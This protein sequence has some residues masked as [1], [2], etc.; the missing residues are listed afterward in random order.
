MK[1][2]SFLALLLV[3]LFLIE[4]IPLNKNNYTYADVAVNYTGQTNT[5]TYNI[6]TTEQLNLLATKVNSG[7]GYSGS[8]FILQNN[9]IYD[10][11]KNK[12]NY[13][14]IGNAANPFSGTF[15]GNGYTISG[16]VSN[17]FLEYDKAKAEGKISDVGIFGRIS[18]AVIKNL[19][20]SNVHFVGYTRVGGI[21]GTAN[22][23]QILDCEALSDVKVVLYNI[24]GAY[25]DKEC[26][27]NIIGYS[28]G[29]T[30]KNC[31]NSSKIAGGTAGIIGYNAGTVQNCFNSG[32]A[33]FTTKTYDVWRNENASNPFFEVQ[34]RKNYGG[35]AFY[36]SSL[37]EDCY[38]LGD[39]LNVRMV[40]GIVFDML[41]GNVTRCYNKGNLKALEFAHGI[42]NKAYSGNS[43]DISNCYNSGNIEANIVSGIMGNVTNTSV[44]YCYNIGTLKGKLVAGI[45]GCNGSLDGINITKC[46]NVGTLT[47][48]G[49]YINDYEEDRNGNIRPV[50]GWKTAG[51]LLEDSGRD[52]GIKSTCFYLNSITSS[53]PRVDGIAKTTMQMKADDFLPLINPIDNNIFIPDLNNM[54]SGYPIFKWQLQIQDIKVTGNTTVERGGITTLVVEANHDSPEKQIIPSVRSMSM[55]SDTLQV[56]STSNT[57]YTGQT[58]IGTY[59]ISTPEQLNLLSTKVNSGITYENSTFIVL[60]DIDFGKQE[61]YKNQTLIKNFTSIGTMNNPFMGMFDGNDKKISNIVIEVDRVGSG[62]G[63]GDI[64]ADLTNE[65]VYKGLFGHSRGTIKNVNIT[66]FRQVNH[67][68]NARW[69]GILVGVNSGIV[70]NCVVVEDDEHLFLENNWGTIKKIHRDK[71]PKSMVWINNGD[72]INCQNKYSLSVYSSW[73]NT[74][75][76]IIAGCGGIATFNHGTIK[77][78]SNIAE[79]NYCNADRLARG[80]GAIA[81]TNLG[82]IEDCFN[83]SNIRSMDIAG[84]VDTNQGTVQRCYNTGGVY[85]NSRDDMEAA[86]I[87]RYN[88]TTG[89]ITDCYNTG[90][91]SGVMETGGIVGTNMG[92]VKGSYNTGN[93]GGGGYSFIYNPHRYGFGGIAGILKGGRIEY[94]YNTG[95]IS[96]LFGQS[97]GIVGAREG[98]SGKIISSYNVG[99][100]HQ[101]SKISGGIIGWN[102]MLTALN[103]NEYTTEE[104]ERPN[105]TIRPGQTVYTG[106]REYN[107]VINS[108]F[109]KDKNKCQ[110]LSMYVGMLTNI[111]DVPQV[112]SHSD[113]LGKSTAQ[114]QEQ[115]FIDMLN[116]SGEKHFIRDIYFTN[117]GYPIFKWQQEKITYD[118]RI[119]NSEI[120]SITP[121]LD[122]NGV[123]LKGLKKGKTILRVSATYNGKII[124]KKVTIT[125]VNPA[126]QT[127][128]GYYIIGEEIE[129][130]TGYSDDDNDP[131]YRDEFKYIHTPNRLEVGINLDNTTGTINYNNKW[132]GDSVNTF[133]KVGA[134]EVNYRVQ[135]NPPTASKIGFENY[136]YYSESVKSTIYI[137]RKP[138]AYFTILN[139]SVTDDSY[140]LDHSISY[141]N[142]GIIKW[143]W[144]YINDN[145]KILTYTATDKG[146]GVNTVNGW[147]S[148]NLGVNYE[149]ILRVQDMEFVWSEIYSNRIKG[150]IEFSANLRTELEKFDLINGVPAS[151][152]L[153]AFDIWTRYA[154]ELRLE[155][156]LCDI[157][158]KEVAP[159]LPVKY[160]SSTATRIGQDTYW[161][162]VL[163]NIPV[164]L[165]SGKY[166]MK[167]RAIDERDSNVFKE[168]PF[169][170]NVKTPINL[171]PVMSNE[172]RAGKEINIAATTSK[173][174]NSAHGGSGVKVTLFDGTSYARTLTMNGTT[175]NWDITTT[176]EKTIPQGVYKAKFVATLPSGELEEKVVNYNFV[177]NTAP[178]IT[179]GEI[180]AELGGN[181]IYENDD[182]NFRLKFHDIDLSSLDID[183]KLYNFSNLTTP[184][185]SYK[186]TVNP[187][188]SVY[189]DY[190]VRL[191]DDIP[192]GDYRVV[193]TVTDDY[194]ESATITKDFIAHDLWVKGSVTHTT[195]WEKNRQT[196]NTKYPSKTRSEDTYWNGESL[197]TS[198]NTTIINSN[199]NVVCN[200]VSVEV[201]NND[202]PSDKHYLQWLN[203][204]ITNDKWSLSYW[205]KEW[206]RKDGYVINKWGADKKQE[207]ILRFKAYFNNDWVET[208]DVKIYIDN[209][210]DYWKLHRAW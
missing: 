51:I 148:S 92:L 117:N 98:F 189:D 149:L 35:I 41:G 39:F 204:N 191:I 24:V 156:V 62:T 203:S 152:N 146:T 17:I 187:N 164:K 104:H 96:T 57:A 87:V 139:N 169:D 143:E 3:I 4:L 208:F 70:E 194:N 30:V 200:K 132:L 190:I 10:N 29:S 5:G 147:L 28:G 9:I 44:S 85:A 59:Y 168:L 84:I 123:V 25:T 138:I 68:D 55:A 179:D 66:A 153:L 207:L 31:S 145:G 23:S 91:I 154:D 83:T 131:K 150:E 48:E 183:I 129:Y 120:A 54:N 93:V 50:P 40:G 122:G 74:E 52:A 36:S 202:K 116:S 32:T 20:I 180:F 127:K 166:I 1:R 140:D 86:G 134:Y 79:A 114:M 130:I 174:V 119:E 175:T 121:I 161:Y 201:I 181:F 73:T 78:C 196:Y 76:G 65:R 112:Y 6:S 133:S 197:E 53:S 210:E 205:D 173:Y 124:T 135:D 206:V 160:S 209:R 109:L 113:I 182:V 14:P 193:A 198:A 151:E 97:G 43:V 170:V 89:I 19:N 72:I 47:N 115:A 63:A 34:S 186:H 105:G 61:I 167:I 178:V 108:F 27:G 136:R 101:D 26:S 49:Y 18:N 37:I 126:V 158:G 118:W 33:D 159:V 46:Y 12:S 184:I 64:T 102:G 21:V 192:L 58:G 2:N 110:Y 77:N 128:D 188:G 22:S 75:N 107:D 99:T 100:V 195:D 13:T 155:L 69:H 60:N 176:L 7:N 142:K 45:I 111:N 42:V 162:D 103:N 95:N 185:K 165:K 15:D 199:S 137:H 163:Y 88:H 56:L 82:L 172:I 157:T 106:T 81:F 80:Y 171:Q 71:N 90:N 177:V 11:S 141:S 38:N 94:C 125:V 67:E 16:T 144:T 8:T